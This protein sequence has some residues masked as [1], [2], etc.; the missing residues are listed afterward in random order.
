VELATADRG[1]HGRF[2]GRQVQGDDPW[3]DSDG[4][5]RG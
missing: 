1:E 4:D 3:S 5:P 2:G